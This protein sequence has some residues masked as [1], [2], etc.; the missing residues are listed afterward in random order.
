MRT[1][2]FQLN[3]HTKSYR[4]YKHEDVSIGSHESFEYGTCFSTIQNV[5][6]QRR[7]KMVEVVS[8]T[9][10]QSVVKEIICRNCG[11]TLRYT[12]N[13]IK[14]R[15]ESDY[16]GCK[17]QVRFIKCPLCGHEIYI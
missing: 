2:Y 11:A 5:S 15:I 12:P 13:D 7:K 3:K 17:E 16:T 10:H 6:R 4:Q 8:T 14:K 9:P 1:Y